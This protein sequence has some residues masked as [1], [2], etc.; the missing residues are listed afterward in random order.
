MIKISV[1]S[2]LTA[3]ALFFVSPAFG[4]NKGTDA[5]CAKTTAH[6]QGVD[7]IDYATLNLTSDQESKIKTWQADCLKAGCTKESRH[8]FLKQAKGI[9]SADQFAK[10]KQQCKM[11]KGEAKTQA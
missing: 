9:L 3:S 7:C 6:S 4:G 1:L 11:H 2:V 5:C 8:A 10:L